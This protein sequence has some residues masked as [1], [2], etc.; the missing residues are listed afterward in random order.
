M[1]EL[2]SITVCMDKRFL[3]RRM[4]LDELEQNLHIVACEKCQLGNLLTLL[5]VGNPRDARDLC[6]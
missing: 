5:F 1:C 6:E 3:L 4:S 2:D